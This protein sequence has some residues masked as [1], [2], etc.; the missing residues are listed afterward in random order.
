MEC[1]IRQKCVIFWDALHSH[2]LG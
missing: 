2:S 1:P